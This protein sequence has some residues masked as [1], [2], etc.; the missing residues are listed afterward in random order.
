MQSY[1]AEIVIGGGVFVVGVG[2]LAGKGRVVRR[3]W[4]DQPDW[5]VGLLLAIAGLFF[6]ISGVVSL[7]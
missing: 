6:V 3:M 2:I 5:Q 7:L 1:P 4:R